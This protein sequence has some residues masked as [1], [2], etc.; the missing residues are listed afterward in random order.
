[1]E[2][3][4]HI[5]YIVKDDPKTRRKSRSILETESFLGN[6][7]IHSEMGGYEFNR[8]KLIIKNFERS[9]EGEISC[10]A[11]ERKKSICFRKK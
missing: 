1:M 9:H 11:K 8:R 5:I 3:H 6:S 10:V 4:C 2:R 7:N